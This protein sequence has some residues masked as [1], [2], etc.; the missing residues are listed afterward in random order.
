MRDFINKFIQGIG[1]D[2]LT[3]FFAC[4]FLTLALGQ[5]MHWSIAVLIVAAIGVAKEWL[6]DKSVNWGD[7]LADGFGIF[8][9]LG[10]LL[11]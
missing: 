8:V 3:H 2:K 9:G 4:A 1:L 5:L 10:F 7:L 11:M 6:I